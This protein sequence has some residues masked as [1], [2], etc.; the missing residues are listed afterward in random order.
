MDDYDGTIKSVF[1][2]GNLDGA[3]VTVFYFFHDKTGSTGLKVFEGEI[4][5]DIKWN[6]GK[7]TLNATAKSRIFSNRIGFATED[8]Q[9]GVNN[10]VAIGKVWPLVFGKAAH[11]PAVLVER[12]PNT[13]LKYQFTL[14]DYGGEEIYD[15]IDGTD[16][17]KKL[18]L[19]DR[20]ELTALRSTNDDGD[21][22]EV[23]SRIYLEDGSGFTQ[24]EVISIEIEGVIFKGT[25]D[26]SDPDVF[27]V[28]EVNAPKYMEVAFAARDGSDPDSD[29]PRVAWLADNTQSVENSFFYFKR[30]DGNTNM[31]FFDNEGR[32]DNDLIRVTKC[33]RQLGTKI[34]LDNPIPSDEFLFLQDS[35]SFTL[36]DDTNEAFEVRGLNLS[37][38]KIEITNALNIASGL[39]A[40]KTIR[41]MKQ[42]KYLMGQS[43][44]T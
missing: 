25:I 21:V 23:P 37:G 14:G 34:W 38:M 40:R 35:D 1:D 3:D 26:S 11:V 24:D 36:I 5:G 18:S 10:D 8:G 28:E 41:E 19:E 44:N 42:Q 9:F 15:I 31:H 7:R 39:L 33:V 12:E 4:A 6:E 43:S 22:V 20:R 32:N 16:G 27:E 17:Y 30:S 2:V 13:E 29:N